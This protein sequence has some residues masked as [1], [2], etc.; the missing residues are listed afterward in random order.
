[1]SSSYLKCPVAFQQS[2]LV[3]YSKKP[4]EQC[5]HK[6][7]F[8]LLLVLD[9]SN[10]WTKSVKA[11]LGGPVDR[12][13]SGL[14][15]QNSQSSPRFR[16][17]CVNVSI[18]GAQILYGMKSEAYHTIC[19]Y[20]PSMPLSRPRTSI[21]HLRC[22]LG[23][24][25]PCPHPEQSPGVPKSPLEPTLE[26]C[27]PPTLHSYDPFILFNDNARVQVSPHTLNAE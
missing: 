6:R 25:K 2:L 24:S 20:S 15:T 26:A 4:A 3:A 7:K 12:P 8:F 11:N 23:I 1:M 10:A 18:L 13:D 16:G 17:N 5:D 27:R 19:S 21:R 22:M 9:N 14:N